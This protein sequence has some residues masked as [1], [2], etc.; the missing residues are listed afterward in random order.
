MSALSLVGDVFYRKIHYLPTPNTTIDLHKMKNKDYCWLLINKDD[1]EITQQAVDL[2]LDTFFNRVKNVCKNNKLKEFYSK[3]LHRI[4]VTKKEHSFYGME[5]DMLCLLCQ[6]PDSISHTFLNCH[7]SKHFFSEVIKWGNK[8]NDTAFSP[9]PLEI[10]FGLE[11]K[12]YPQ[13]ANKSK[14]I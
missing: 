11:Q 2:N 9:S 10:L 3:L 14:K 8:E 4:V 1:V 12:D 5:S 13:V 6:E 7:W